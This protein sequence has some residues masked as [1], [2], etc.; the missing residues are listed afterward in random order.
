M[1]TEELGAHGPPGFGAKHPT[2]HRVPAPLFCL[3]L[4]DPETVANREQWL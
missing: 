2:I 4:S 3:W 1:V